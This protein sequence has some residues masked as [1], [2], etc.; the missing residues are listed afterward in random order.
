MPPEFEIKAG[1]D[2]G[3]FELLEEIA[4]GGMGVVFKARHKQLGRIV[5]LKTIRPAA[6]RPGTDAIQRFR[7]EAEAVARLDHPHIVPIYEMGEYGGCP[8]ISLKLIGGGDLERHIPRLKNDPRASARL[9]RDVARAVHYAHLRGILHRDLKPSN[10]LLDDRGLP[11][12][13]DFGLAKCVEEDS[14]LTQTGLILG[15]PSYMA[16]EQVEG[17]RGEVTTAADIYGLGAVLYRLLTGRPPFQGDSVYETLRQVK[18]QEPVPPAIHDPYVDRDLAAICLKSL[19]KSPGR[20]YGSAEAMADDLDRWLSGEPISARPIGQFRRAWRWCGRNRV[21][22]GLSASVV[23]LL[24][25]VAA[26]ATGSAIRQHALRVKAET[27]AAQATAAA[28]SEREAR[29]LADARAGEIRWRLVRMNVE[30]G[31]R[32]SDQGDLAGALCGSPRALGSIATTRPARRRTVCAS[33]PCSSKALSSIR[34]SR[35]R[36]SSTGL[37]STRLAGGSPLPRPIIRP[38]SGMLKPAPRSR[39]RLRTTDRSTG[40]SFAAMGPVS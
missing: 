38:G 26:L 28:D 10:I 14:G 36:G 16:P 3:A 21:V 6:F 25:A 20:R 31:N 2:F 27:S 12:V 37:L 24:V 11:H 33:E 17:H 23:G 9:M 29:H 30:N 5:A 39:H 1:A 7:I 32:I 35:I 34:S 18:E 4:T 8:Y 15:T 19:E 22:A 40:S 13:T